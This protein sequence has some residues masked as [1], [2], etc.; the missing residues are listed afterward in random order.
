MKCCGEERDGNF[1]P[2]CGKQLRYG[3]GWELLT[4]VRTSLKACRTSKAS[5]ER[6]GGRRIPRDETIKKWERW[7]V[8]LESVLKDVERPDG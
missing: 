8:W 1:C 2:V 7:Q 5:N 3:P 6:R 4:F